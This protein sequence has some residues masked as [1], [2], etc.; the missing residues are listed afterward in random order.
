MKISFAH[1]EN[2]IEEAIVS[3][4]EADPSYVQKVFQIFARLRIHKNMGGDLLNVLNE[5][6]GIPNVIS[7][8]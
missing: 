7:S 2:L 5:I 8:Y 3:L 1:L 4:R 6:R